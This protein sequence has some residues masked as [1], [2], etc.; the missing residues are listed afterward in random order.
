MKS[1]KM[2]P[3]PRTPKANHPLI[4]VAKRENLRK[5]A[6]LARYEMKR[7]YRSVFV[8]K[9]AAE[10]GIDN[11]KARSEKPISARNSNAVQPW[12]T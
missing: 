8:A 12:D 1:A 4:G 7:I 5:R 3:I 2:R 6:G 11:A 9:A 10:A